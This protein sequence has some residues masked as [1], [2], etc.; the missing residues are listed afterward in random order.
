[1][2]DLLLIAQAMFIIFLEFSPVIIAAALC[3]RA[4][5]KSKN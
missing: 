4:T 5:A 3:E 2:I 1:M